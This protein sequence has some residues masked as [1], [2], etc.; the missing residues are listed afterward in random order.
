MKF[1]V[2]YYRKGIKYTQIEFEAFNRVEALHLC[3][4][5]VVKTKGGRSKE[6]FKLLGA[7]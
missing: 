7:V 1:R 2:E 6:T 5:A 3:K 4:Q